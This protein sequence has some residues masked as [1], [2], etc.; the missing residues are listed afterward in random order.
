MRVL[1][2]LPSAAIVGL[3]LVGAGG[4]WLRLLEPGPG[5]RLFGLGILVAATSALLL[6]AAAAL[7]TARGRAWRS[8]A[9]RAAALPVGIS[10]VLLVLILS[11][12]SHPIHD[13]TTD[14]TLEFPAEIAQLREPEDRASV[15]AQQ[16]ELYPDIAPLELVGRSRG[17]ALSLAREVAEEMWSVTS[18]DPQA[19]RILAIAESRI[20]HF[21]DDVVVAV[22]GEPGRDARVQVRSRSRIGQ[23]DLGANAER[24]RAY[25]A[26]VRARAG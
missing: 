17:E 15:L 24:I 1:W 7:A 13:V 14:P 5:F 23:S 21:V 22:E 3:M 4:A 2:W 19:G 10:V 16:A 6:S 9:V 18:V 8:D 11:G 20:F 25:L 12:G 26:A